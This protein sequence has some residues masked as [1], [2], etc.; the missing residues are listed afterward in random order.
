MRVIPRG[1]LARTHLEVTQ[2]QNSVKSCRGKLI[3]SFEL[4][5]KHTMDKGPRPVPYDACQRMQKT[6]GHQGSHGD[7]SFGWN[8]LESW[9]P[10]CRKIWH[11]LLARARWPGPAALQASGGASAAMVHLTSVGGLYECRK[12]RVAVFKRGH[13]DRGVAKRHQLSGGNREGTC[14]RG[15]GR[16][17][18]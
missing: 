12:G 18:C 9:M 6:G 11:P 15:S 17:R 7:F 1:L 8:R 10:C 4:R 14:S 2:R 16:C 5:C 13:S 3:I